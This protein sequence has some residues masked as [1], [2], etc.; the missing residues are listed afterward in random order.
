MWFRGVT[1]IFKKYLIFNEI[2]MKNVR[3]REVWWNWQDACHIYVATTKQTKFFQK[4]SNDIWKEEMYEET[5][6]DNLRLPTNLL[7]NR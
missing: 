1:N 2:R 6:F 5:F 4:A 3:A 7:N